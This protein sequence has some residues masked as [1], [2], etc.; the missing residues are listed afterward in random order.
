MRTKIRVNDKWYKPVPWH[1]DGECDG[2][3][4]D[5]D[6]CINGSANVSGKFAGLCD[7]D[8]EFGG[9]IFIHNTKESL[10]KYVAKRLEGNQ[11]EEEDT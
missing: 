9:M 11:E 10:A 6:G 1:V 3:V 4:F 2:C 5:G 8:C 7:P